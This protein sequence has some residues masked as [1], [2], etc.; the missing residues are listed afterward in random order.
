MTAAPI[1]ER[2]ASPPRRTIAIR[3]GPRTLR[4]DFGG[5]VRYG[6]VAK[7]LTM[8]D[9]AREVRVHTRTVQNWE[10][11]GME[12]RHYQVRLRLANVLFEEGSKEYRMI[13]G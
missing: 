7:G 9:L 1:D 6:R 11:H 10:I 4:L 12:P 2:E 3:L 8:Q 5:L 13:I